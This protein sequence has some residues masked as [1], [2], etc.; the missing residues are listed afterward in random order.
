M[1]V[2]R[3]VDELRLLGYPA[4]TLDRD[5][6]VSLI[7]SVRNGVSL[8]HDQSQTEAGVSAG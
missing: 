5:F 1:G 8:F 3:F 6:G 7:Q 4:I 2:P